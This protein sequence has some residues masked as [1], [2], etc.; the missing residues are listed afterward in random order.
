QWFRDTAYLRI[1][2]KPVLLSFGDS[3][4]TG[5]EWSEA[6]RSEQGRILYF[7]EHYRRPAA[8]GA[9]DWPEPSLGFAALDTFYAEARNHAVSIPVAFPR[10]Y[11]AYKMGKARESYPV[12]ADD[13]GRTFIRTL[14][15]AL[16]SG[17]PMVQIATWNDW[18]EGTSIEPSRE[19]GYRD[20][21]Q[22]Q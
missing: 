18:G 14:E 17:A 2:G 20:L 9:F 5:A 4:L 3:G 22:I 15:R 6:M 8:A 21:E 10:F 13:N 19:F 11:D 16:K 1:D 7:S 12:I